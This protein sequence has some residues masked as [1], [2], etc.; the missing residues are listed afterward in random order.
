[1]VKAKPI[2][3]ADFWEPLLAHKPFKDMVEAKYKYST[4]SKMVEFDQDYEG[5]FSK[6]ELDELKSKIK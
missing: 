1:M 5:D 4:D 6:D 3:T 2:E